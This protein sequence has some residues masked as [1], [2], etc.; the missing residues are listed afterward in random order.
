MNGKLFVTIWNS[1]SDADAQCITN[2]VWLVPVQLFI[3]HPNTCPIPAGQL[4]VSF[5]FGISMDTTQKVPCLN[6]VTDP[7]ISS[8]P[9]FSNQPDFSSQ[10]YYGAKA[11]IQP[12][13]S[14][15]NS[16]SPITQLQADPGWLHNY[17]P[18]PSFPVINDASFAVSNAQQIAC[19]G[20]YWDA[21]EHR[22]IAEKGSYVV[23]VKDLRD[24]HGNPLNDVGKAFSVT[25][26]N[27]MARP[28]LGIEER[29]R[30]VHGNR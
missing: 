2:P 19:P 25:A 21:D 9:Y 23:Y 18:G 29:E 11:Y 15:G 27:A 10:P 12:L 1:T 7:S 13:D 30:K 17:L 22:S 8:R 28:A 14:S 26:S 6:C 16:A 4:K 3:T 24:M 20:A 5:K